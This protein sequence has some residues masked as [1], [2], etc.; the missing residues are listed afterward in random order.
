MPTLVAFGAEDGAPNLAVVRAV[1]IPPLL[2]K[3]GHPGIRAAVRWFRPAKP[4]L[5]KSTFAKPTFS[6]DEAVAKMATRFGGEALIAPKFYE[7]SQME[8]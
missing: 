7:E 5:A 2:R 6:D 8:E 3:D 1:F 4:T